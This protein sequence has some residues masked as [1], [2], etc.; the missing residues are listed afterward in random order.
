MLYNDG[1]NST[2][3]YDYAMVS[4]EVSDDIKCPC[5]KF[6][7]IMSEMATTQF[8]P[9]PIAPDLEDSTNQQLYEPVDFQASLGS[10][11]EKSDRVTA[12]DSHDQPFGDSVCTGTEAKARL[13]SIVSSRQEAD[14]TNNATKNNDANGES[15]VIEK[16]VADPATIV[17][18][19][20]ELQHADKKRLHA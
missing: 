3:N 5:L 7:I 4:G 9:P 8:V 15:I 16:D 20:S 10:D 14:K 11:V 1:A 19:N 6:F 12:S 13:S 17:D 2:D 18:D